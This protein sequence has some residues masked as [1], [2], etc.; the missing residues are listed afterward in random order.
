M[1]LVVAAEPVM[2]DLQTFAI[3]YRP[4]GKGRQPAFDRVAQRR[5]AALIGEAFTG[6]LGDD[7]FLPGV[8]FDRG[9]ALESFP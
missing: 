9:R 1:R 5:F 7:F 3:R 8:G 6:A 2:Q 4:M